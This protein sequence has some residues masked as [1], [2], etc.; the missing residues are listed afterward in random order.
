VPGTFIPRLLGVP[1]QS[2]ARERELVSLMSSAL[3]DDLRRAGLNAR[4]LPSGETA[5]GWLVAPLGG[6]SPRNLSS[7]SILS[8]DIRNAESC[9][10]LRAIKL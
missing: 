10:T 5:V 7:R 4:S 9:E 3:V 2:A 8:I 6:S 1:E